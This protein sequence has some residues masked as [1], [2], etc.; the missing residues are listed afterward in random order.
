M[1]IL[2][3]LILPTLQPAPSSSCPGTLSSAPGVAVSSVEGLL[4]SEVCPGKP[5]EYV[6]LINHG[7]DRTVKGLVVTDG[8]GNI[9]VL[10]DLTLRSGTSIA[11]V[12]NASLFLAVH[13]GVMCLEK[14]SAD[15]AWGGRFALA[16]AGDTVELLCSG[17]V[18]DTLSYGSSQ[19]TGGGWS[20]PSVAS[21]PK[22][23]AA[24][25]ADGD[26]D[27][28]T[29]WSVEP[30][31]RS[32]LQPEQLQAI[33]EPFSAPE[34][35]AERL[36][37]EIGLATRTLN[38]SVYELT[39]PAVVTALAKS[40]RRGIDVNVLLEGQPVGGLSNASLSAI[41]TLQASGVDVRLLR[42]ADSYKRYDYLHAKYLVA[43][44]RRTVVMS[45]NWGV[46]LNANRGWGACLDGAGIAA[47][48]DHMFSLDYNGII[49]VV[50]P[51]VNI[52]TLEPC[53]IPEADLGDLVRFRCP[54]MPVLSPD[55]SENILHDLFATAQ[56]RILVEQLSVDKGWLERSSLVADLI[57]AAARGVQVRLLLDSS[58]GG[59]E[60]RE[61]VERLNVLAASNALDLDARMISDYHGLSVMHNKGVIVDDQ[62]V[63]S[64]INWGDSSLRQN[65]EA[66]VVIS[67]PDIADL[68][69]ELFWSDWSVDPTPP[70]ALLPWTNMT[71]HQG[72]V[73]FLDGTF[74]H[75]NARTLSY[76]WDL[77]ADGTVDNTSQSWAVHLPPGN[78][79]IVLT[80]RD[81]GNN[82]AT[83]ACWVL[84]LPSRGEDAAFP[85]LILALPL[86]ALAGVIVLKRI[87]GRKRH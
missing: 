70:T 24:V 37:R 54:V 10:K 16:D 22:A 3:V 38:C 40:A 80:V 48:F 7:M 68:F 32:E 25:R 64:S 62:T 65:R 56:G 44:G 71:Y 13:P 86:T 2:L 39:D 12:A 67:S 82:T 55:T 78:H 23:H 49:D 5:V 52:P 59:K 84:V 61:V 9:T 20:G 19:Y 36:M 58:W 76:E 60:N 43:D 14:G 83:V 34:N 17:R 21:I 8:E 35:A 81:I 74:S 29:D 87:I 45:E 6:M 26:S 53:D 1:I 47:Y 50:T 69:A 85:T 57:S 79:T 42:S 28:A 27:T 73:A 41:A 72:E 11:L 4:L 66:G 63:I 46:G 75:D 18:V 15:L 30:P 33:V 31:G 51:A 77:G